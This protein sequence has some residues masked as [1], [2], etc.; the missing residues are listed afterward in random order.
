L[1]LGGFAACPAELRG[2]IFFLFSS[3]KGAE[4]QRNC[5]LLGLTFRRGGQ[6]SLLCGLATLRANYFLFTLAKTQRRKE[7][8]VHF[9]SAAADSYLSACRRPLRLGVFAASPAEL[10]GAI[11]FFSFFFS[12]NRRG[13]KELWST[14]IDC[15]RQENLDGL[16]SPPQRIGRTRP[17]YGKDFFTKKRSYISVTPLIPLSPPAILRDRPAYRTSDLL[18]TRRD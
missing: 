5:D 14:R 4:T 17:A 13:A 12:Q 2:A 11:F 7:I 6:A 3:R 8:V 1:R 10:R 18:I 9:L 15:R 16:A